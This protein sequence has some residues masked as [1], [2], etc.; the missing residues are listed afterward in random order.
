MGLREPHDTH[1][2]LLLLFFVVV[3]VVSRFQTKA[4]MQTSLQNFVKDIPLL[5]TA[6][7]SIIIFNFK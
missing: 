3:V 7:K 6:S 1:T 5:I 2:F 4:K